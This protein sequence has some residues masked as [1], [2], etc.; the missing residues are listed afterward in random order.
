MRTL[1]VIL[2]LFIQTTL[3][4]EASMPSSKN[5]ENIDLNIKDHEVAVTFL[6]LSEGEAT[7]IQGANDENI[8]VNA[9]GKETV[10]ELEGWLYLYDV[11]KISKLILT[12]NEQELTEKQFNRL[13]SKYHIREIITTPELS[14]KII[15]ELS[16]TNKPAVVTW[17]ASTKKRILPEMTAVV[18][19]VGKDDNE[20]MDLTLEFFKHRIF[21]MTSFTSRA[22]E[23]LMTKDLE[24]INVFKI[25]KYAMKD[26]LSEKLIEY[27][28]PQIS[29]LFAPEEGRHDPDI[30]VDLHESWSEIYSTK[31]HGTITIKFTDSNYEV[32]TIPIEA[33]E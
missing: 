8:L 18:Q 16:T 24:N 1:L 5:I 27:L 2:S 10:A 15:K 28:N 19:F 33:D 7:L 4:V 11:K 32:I 30:L 29:I 25:P 9:G 20:G 17:G 31:K 14:G 23:T 26:A 13:I 12:K 21:L 6:G 22:E 3:M